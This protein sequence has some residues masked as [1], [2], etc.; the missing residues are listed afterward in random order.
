MTQVAAVVLLGCIRLEKNE[1]LGDLWF[2][3]FAAVTLVT[4][5]FGGMVLCFRRKKYVCL[6]ATCELIYLVLFSIQMYQFVTHQDYRVKKEGD[7]SVS[8]SIIEGS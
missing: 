1:D 6:F 3:A 4:I 8:S 5:N 2:V 7:E